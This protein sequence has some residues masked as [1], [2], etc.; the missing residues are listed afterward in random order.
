MKFATTVLTGQANVEEGP[1]TQP[2]TALVPDNS[3]TWFDGSAWLLHVS[4]YRA[5]LAP[6]RPDDEISLRQSRPVLVVSYAWSS[7]VEGPDPRAYCRSE[8]P[9]APELLIADDPP[10]NRAGD[11]PGIAGRLRRPLDAGR[12]FW[13]INRAKADAAMRFASA[14]PSSLH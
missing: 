13:A 14:N 4:G 1:A 6:G 7:T 5:I 3:R 9:G 2:S 12:F 10:D 8:Y 11:Q